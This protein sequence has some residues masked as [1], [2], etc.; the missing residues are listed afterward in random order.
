MPPPVPD[1]E[2]SQEII[3]EALDN[4]T[5][6]AHMDGGKVSNVTLKADDVYAFKSKGKISLEVSDGGAVSIVYNGK[7]KGVPGVLGQPIKLRFP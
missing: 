6:Q 4:V 7:D 1:L 5:V 3:I 2:K